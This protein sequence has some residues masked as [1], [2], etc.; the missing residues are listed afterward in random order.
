MNDEKR[1][2]RTRASEIPLSSYGFLMERT[3]DD[4]IPAAALLCGKFFFGLS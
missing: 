1:A 2:Y 4:Q 3:V